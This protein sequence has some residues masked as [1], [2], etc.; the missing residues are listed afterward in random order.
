MRG[1]AG[2][3]CPY[4]DQ[5]GSKRLVHPA[6]AL[7]I[8]RNS[9]DVPEASRIRQTTQVCQIR[10]GVVF[11]SRSRTDTRS[12]YAVLGLA[13]IHDILLADHKGIP[14]ISASHAGTN[15]DLVT[16]ALYSDKGLGDREYGMRAEESVHAHHSLAVRQH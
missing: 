15:L 3:R 1:A 4:R 10:L 8:A 9:D 7:T 11:G 2:N 6:L 12:K 14:A 13:G 16:L 5:P